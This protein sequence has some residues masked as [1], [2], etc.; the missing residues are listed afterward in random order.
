MAQNTKCCTPQDAL[1]A[2]IK[3]ECSTDHLLLNM[4]LSVR[5]L[6]YAERGDN[7]SRIRGRDVGY[8]KDF[9]DDLQ[10]SFIEFHESARTAV[11]SLSGARVLDQGERVEAN[12][13]TVLVSAEIRELA[14]LIHPTT[15]GYDGLGLIRYGVVDLPQRFYDLYNALQRRRVVLQGV[16]D[17]DQTDWLTV[18]EAAIEPMDCVSGLTIDKAKSRVSFAATNGKFTTNGQKGKDRRIEKNSFSSWLLEQREIDLDKCDE[19][20]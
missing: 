9:C 1:D 17:K 10:D 15:Y 3:L 6:G 5:L 20:F 8:E 19:G 7:Q 14:G 13:W 11:A 2:L 4:R 16:A 18:T 12:K